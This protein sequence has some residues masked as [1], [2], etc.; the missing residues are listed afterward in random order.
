[1][2]NKLCVENVLNVY[3][4]LMTSDNLWKKKN[5]AI[6][7]QCHVLTGMGFKFLH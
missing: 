3:R 1:M 7:W 5:R 2:G 4:F 6:L